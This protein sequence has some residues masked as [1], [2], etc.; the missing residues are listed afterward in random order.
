M[1]SINIMDCSISYQSPNYLLIGS[2]GSGKGTLSEFLSKKG[3]HIIAMGERLRHEVRAE[4]I[5]GKR[6]KNN[7]DQGILIPD[8]LAFQ[9]I[10]QEIIQAPRP[11]AI[12]GFPSTINQ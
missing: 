11:F 1:R 2:P 8:D 3:Y 9:I 6:I 7:V 10:S 12:E 4:T 5:L